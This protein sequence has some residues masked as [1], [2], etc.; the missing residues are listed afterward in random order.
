ML[1]R[2]EKVTVTYDCES[3]LVNKAIQR[4]GDLRNTYFTMRCKQTAAK[5]RVFRDGQIAKA[6]DEL[7][8]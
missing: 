5:L 6:V 4:G 7:G 1:L 2:T 3:K 8:L